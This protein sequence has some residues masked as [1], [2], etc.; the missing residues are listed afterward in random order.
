MD[1]DLVERRIL[2]FGGGC[3]TRKRLSFW[4]A[5]LLVTSNGM[6]SFKTA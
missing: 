5:T 3:P 1:Q 2:R 4:R 6:V